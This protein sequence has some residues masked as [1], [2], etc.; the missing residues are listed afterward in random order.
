MR[1][2]LT[3]LAPAIKW[4][5]LLYGL[6]FFAISLLPF[7]PAP[8]RLAWML[9]IGVTE[10]GHI[11]ALFGLIPLMPSFR[12]SRPALAGAAFGVAGIALA[13]SSIVRACW[14]AGDVCVELQRAFGDAPVRFGVD[15]APARPAPIVLSD[16]P[17]GISC[18][19]VAL[20]TV[21]YASP[22]GTPLEM[23]ICA[24]PARD[25][26]SPAAPILLTIHGGSWR[27]GNRAELPAINRYLASRGYCVA[28]ID[29][30]LAPAHKFP[31]AFEDI[32]AAVDYLK[33]NAGSLHV[34]PQRIA[35]FGRSAGGN[36]A[37]LGAYRLNDPDIRG[38]IAVYAPTDLVY[39]YSHPT[40]PR[41][42]NSKG[43]LEDFLGGTPDTAATAYH[44]ASPLNFVDARTP[45]TL[46][47]HGDHDDFVGLVHSERLMER[48][49][50]KRRPALL[51]K[52]PWGNHGCDANLS[53]PGGQIALFAIERFLAA[54]LK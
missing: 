11:F 26:A 54:T 43:V 31:A 39:G 23:D 3:R 52:I 2:F 14:M 29:Y 18:P 32:R 8:N 10:W 15:N 20:R 6:V 42:L 17:F 16:I 45:A 22:G 53:G 49:Q 50:A 47:I 12:K 44:D 34:D 40:N 36:L 7:F 37:L 1:Q 9:G 24:P 38:V 13:L 46:L 48:L 19:D 35:L 27:S 30:R 25:P 5:R 33:K 28:S 51:L 4:L 41:V 21:V